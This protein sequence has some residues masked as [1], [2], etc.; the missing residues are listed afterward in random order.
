MPGIAIVED[1]YIVALDI[2]SFLERSG[3]AIA[4]M[5]A[6]GEDLLEG[7]A[8]FRPDLI[9]MDI[10]LRGELDGV[11][12]ARLVHERYGTPVVLLTAFADDETIARA[13]ITQPF[14]YLIKPFEERELKISMRSR[15]T[16][17]RWRRS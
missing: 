12:T 14:G 8:S 4:G 13:K 2:K 7:F 10:K 6:S 11:E 5:Y 17:P 1:E 16:G 9:L 3:F 15:Y